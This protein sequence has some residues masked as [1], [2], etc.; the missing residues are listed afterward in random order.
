VLECLLPCKKYEF[1]TTNQAEI[2][3]L[4][5]TPGEP[6]P[7]QEHRVRQVF[8]WADKVFERHTTKTFNQVESF[9]M[10]VLVT[11]QQGSD[12][13]DTPILV[14]HAGRAICRWDT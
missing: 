7:I 2:D 11:A 1:F 5:G 10:S 12:K 14:Q 6:V 13:D 9:A 4:R 3:R 8:E